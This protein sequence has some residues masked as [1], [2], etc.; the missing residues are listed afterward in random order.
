M[1]HLRDIS[2]PCWLRKCCNSSFLP[3]R[4][5]AFQQA[6]CRGLLQ[7]VLLGRAAIFSHNEDNGLLDSPRTGHSGGGKGGDGSEQPPSQLNK[8]LEEKV[9]EEIL[10]VLE[11]GGGRL[12]GYDQVIGF[13]FDSHGFDAR[14]CFLIGFNSSRHS[15]CCRF[16]HRL[17][18]LGRL[19][20]GCHV[21][22]LG[23]LRDR[24][25]S[26]SGSWRR[27]FGFDNSPSSDDVAPP[28]AQAHLLGRW[29]GLLSFRGGRVASG[30]ALTTLLERPLC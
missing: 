10:D 20:G 4:P 2:T 17:F 22:G 27:R 12:W 30:G 1:S 13:G 16:R 11:C 28:L 15:G 18:R 14:G 8:C 29:P 24:L 23:N 6:R 7:F 5:S 25:R 9:V 21:W 3:S 26:W 19:P